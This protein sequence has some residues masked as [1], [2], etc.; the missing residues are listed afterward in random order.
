[1]AHPSLRN[2]NET[3]ANWREISFYYCSGILSLAF[4]YQQSLDKRRRGIVEYIYSGRRA[5]CLCRLSWMGPILPLQ[6][7]YS[8]SLSSSRFAGWVLLASLS[9]LQIVCALEPISSH[10][11]LTGLIARLRDSS[12]GTSN[13]EKMGENNKKRRGQI[14]AYNVFQ[15]LDTLRICFQI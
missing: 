15:A 8:P 4:A 9:G 3:A 11:F 10:W 7:P 1:M 12:N 13:K 5:G 6:L 14:V 2:C